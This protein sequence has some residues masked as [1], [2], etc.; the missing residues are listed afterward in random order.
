MM[1]IHF[2]S[3]SNLLQCQNNEE[4]KKKKI[5]IDKPH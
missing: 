5:H 2:G 3:T 4:K 1:D